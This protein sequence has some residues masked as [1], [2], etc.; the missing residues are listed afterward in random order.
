MIV[1]D[2]INW[3]PRQE[4]QLAYACLLVTRS[5]PRKSRTWYLSPRCPMPLRSFEALLMH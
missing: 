5:C 1:A 2:M 4:I 3:L